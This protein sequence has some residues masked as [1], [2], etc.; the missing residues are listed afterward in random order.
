M[1]LMTIS[2][3]AS[4]V[5][6]GRR[7]GATALTAGLLAVAVYILATPTGFA[8]GDGPELAAAARMLGTAHPPGYPLYL[9]LGRLAGAVVGDGLVGLRW[10]SLLSVGAAT[11]L[12]Y[13][14]LRRFS[15]RPAVAFGG[16][17]ALAGSRLFIQ[18]AARAE[19]YGPAL[20][21]LAALL[22]ALSRCLLDEVDQT[23]PLTLA[24]VFALALGHQLTLAAFAPLV[25]Y[26][27]VRFARTAHPPLRFYALWLTA[28]LLG[29]SVFLYL[30][31]RSS[32][33]P[34]LAWF[35]PD[36][37]PN[38]LHVVGGGSYGDF[39]GV[40][41]GQYWHNAAR[42][43]RYLLEQWPAYLIVTAVGGAVVAWRRER[44][45][46]C[47]LLLVVLLDFT[48]A[49]GYAA[50]DLE[51]FLL[52]AG[53]LLLFLAVLALGRGLEWL[54][55]RL[56]KKR[57]L[58]WSHV[59]AAAPGLALL[60]GGALLYGP[61]HQDIVRPH[62]DNLLR[63]VPADGAAF[64]NGDLAFPLLEA[65]FVRDRRPDIGVADE[66]G[67]ILH[68]V[69]RRQLEERLRS[70]A[71]IYFADPPTGLP[72]PPVERFGYGYL[73]PATPAEVTPYLT[74]VTG[75][76]YLAAEV[77]V[78]Y[79]LARL[80]SAPRRLD[81]ELE[82]R[83]LERA[84]AAADLSPHAHLALGLYLLERDPAAAEARFR[85]AVEL[86]PWWPSARFDLALALIQQ[87]RRRE[88]AA[89]LSTALEGFGEAEVRARAARLLSELS[90]G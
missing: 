4:P 41:G 67:F 51:V 78:R 46:S 42:L 22:W 24:L 73:Y 18:H 33:A 53:A 10:L 30:P 88:A 83:L 76:G 60:V 43:G 48:W 82:A 15:E 44:L 8:L 28:F 65:H 32:T 29:L 58:P 7:D 87:D 2:N 14:T 90:G 50:Y 9:Q 36:S 59:L 89:E 47:G 25:L 3:D 54:L 16:A 84:V 12:F 39:W 68:P 6:H 17:L 74:R 77:E 80:E 35:R 61:A 40:G 86:D 71:A 20:L 37:L 21:G 45:L 5:P 66:G 70:G 69:R 62:G 19:V 38:L 55:D 23:R 63:A 72:A 79:L 56:E 31:L 13:L 75:E 34:A 1:S 81:G 11:V 52:P 57:A 64:F 26:A 49:A 85:R 27:V